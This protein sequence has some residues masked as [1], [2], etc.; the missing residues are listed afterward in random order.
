MRVRACVCVW[1]GGQSCAWRLEE[2]TLLLLEKW[3]K[4]GDKHKLGR[5]ATSADSRTTR[6]RIRNRERKCFTLAPD[7]QLHFPVIYLARAPE[8]LLD[9]LVPRDR[10]GAFTAGREPHSAPR[11]APVLPVKAAS[12]LPVVDLQLPQDREADQGPAALATPG[13][14]P[15]LLTKIN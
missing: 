2:V 14:S 4:I 1:G 10:A 5:M 6:S 9:A 15:Q 8:P 13:I 3:R 7:Q 12:R 11:T